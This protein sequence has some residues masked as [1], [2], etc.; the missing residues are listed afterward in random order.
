MKS[1]LS[2]LGLSKDIHSMDSKDND[3]GGVKV[4]I[5]KKKPPTGTG[6][7]LRDKGRAYYGLSSYSH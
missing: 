7:H 1:V 4:T 3:R 2:Q 6:R 5:Q